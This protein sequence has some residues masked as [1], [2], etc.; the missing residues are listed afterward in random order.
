MRFRFGRAPHTLSSGSVLL[1]NPGEIHAP[2]PASAHGWSFRVFFFEDFSLAGKLPEFGIDT[3]KFSKPFVQDPILAATLLRL[4]RQLESHGTALES[5]SLLLTIFARLADKHNGGS[6]QKLRAG[7]ELIRVAKAKEYIAANHHRNVTLDELA[8]L[9]QF[10]PYH[11]LRIFR[12][13]VGLTPHAYLTQTRI[14]VAKR[15]LQA[16]TSIA[17]AAHAA[18]FVDQSHFTRQFKRLLG[19]T[20]GQY[21]PGELSTLVAVHA[22][23]Q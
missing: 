17:R 6:I 18:G 10:S 9:T 5:E 3:F 21:L 19:V 4:H 22:E 8:K 12:R 7:K 14:E 1:L 15:L 13:A 20:P 2:G 11:F 16:G 23:F